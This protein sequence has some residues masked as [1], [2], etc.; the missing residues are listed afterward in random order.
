MHSQ[1]K[2]AVKEA[3]EDEIYRGAAH[4]TCGKDPGF[5]LARRFERWTG[6]VG[7]MAGKRLQPRKR[8]RE[9]GRPRGTNGG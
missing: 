6:L 2:F 4:S 8:S 7:Q 5:Y 3:Q 1:K 9:V